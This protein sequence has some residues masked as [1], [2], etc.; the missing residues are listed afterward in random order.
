MFATKNVKRQVAILFVVALK[1][2]GQ[3]IAVD[4]IVSGV[5]WVSA[6]KSIRRD[7]I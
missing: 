6:K 7:P 4:R 1:E 3:L 5:G 2:A